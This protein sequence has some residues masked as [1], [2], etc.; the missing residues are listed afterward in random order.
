[1]TSI[2]LKTTGMHCGS[3]AKRVELAV[4]DLPGVSSVKADAAVGNTHV[5]FDAAQVDV[6]AIVA[7]IRGEGYEAEPT[8]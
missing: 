8:A 7:A 3:C 6:D 2:D 4:G 5:E 1:M